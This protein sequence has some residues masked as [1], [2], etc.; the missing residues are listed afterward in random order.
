MRLH[1]GRTWRELLTD[2]AAAGTDDEAADQ[3]TRAIAELLRT[4]R[5]QVLATPERCRRIGRAY[6][7]SGRRVR[8]LI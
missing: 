2:A 7:R 3:L 1:L 6:Q 4:D 5:D 8:D